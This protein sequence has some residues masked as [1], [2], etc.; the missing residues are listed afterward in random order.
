MNLAG[1]RFAHFYNRLKLRYNS[2]P[3]DIKK[4]FL[5]LSKEFHP[6][7]PKTG[8]H[9]KFL[10]LREAYE[11]IKDAP[12]LLRNDQLDEGDLSHYAYIRIAARKSGLKIKED[13]SSAELPPRKEDSI[14]KRRNQLK[15]YN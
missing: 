4:Q 15:L 6:D 9:K 7:N 8:S 5:N 2:T 13:D 14:W 1:Q 3:E 12:M 10:Q 11:R